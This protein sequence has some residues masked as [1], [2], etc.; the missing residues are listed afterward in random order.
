MV[1]QKSSNEGLVKQLFAVGAQF[2]YS[3]SRSHPSLRSFIFGFKNRHAVIDLEQTASQLARASD[4]VKQLAQ[5]GKEVLWVGNK[6]EARE[7]VRRVAESLS[8]PYVASRWLGGT[9]TNWTQIKG[10]IERLKD[11]KQ[12]REKGELSIYTKKERLLIDREIARL[13]RY[14]ESLSGMAKLPAAVVVIDPQQ[15]M[16]VVREARQMKIPVIALIGSDCDIAGITYPVVANDA[17]IQSIKFFTE[18]LAEAY[19]AGQKLAQVAAPAAV[20]A[21]V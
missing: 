5:E 12:K 20:S 9:F 21:T 3:K 14:L 11:L 1:N 8:A 6:D 13:E 16:I 17:S 18:Q 4:F 2:G 7:A 19:S 15:E 10:R